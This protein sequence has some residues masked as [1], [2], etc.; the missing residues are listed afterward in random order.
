[1]KITCS[2]RDSRSDVLAKGKTWQEFITNL[3][4]EN[5]VEVDSAY[6][7]KYSDFIEFY[8]DG[9]LYEGEV[10][11]Y[12]DDDYEL[13]NQNVKKVEASKVIA[14]TDDETYNERYIH[15][16]IKDIQDEIGDF[17]EI[18]SFDIYDDNIIVEFSDME[19]SY[20]AY[21]PLDD[22]IM[23]YEYS[24]Q[25]MNTV[26]RYIRQAMESDG[27]RFVSSKDVTDSDGFI[28]KYTWYKSEDGN[29]VFVFGDPDM[30][31]PEDGNFDYE[32]DN[33]EVAQEWFNSYTG[34]DD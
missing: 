22:L 14:D 13:L 19:D 16:L 30:Y 33:D 20:T 21:I 32:T 12:F 7:D 26:I 15:S 27:Y 24:A 5:D 10:T 31:R 1:M 3:E 29:N 25:D 2:K 9:Q 17:I 6:K 23:D 34:F 11:K 4:T 8:R 28:T 18:E